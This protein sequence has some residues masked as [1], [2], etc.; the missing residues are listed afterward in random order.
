VKKYVQT[1]AVLLVF[2]T[3]AVPAR[4]EGHYKSFTV[5]T[6][7]IQGT[8]QGL[9]NGNPDPAAY[10]LY[11]NCAAALI[12]DFRRQRRLRTFQ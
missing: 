1:L 7:A 10:L 11:I 12:Y 5:S 4:A 6:Y 9:M 3:F 8:V 2:A